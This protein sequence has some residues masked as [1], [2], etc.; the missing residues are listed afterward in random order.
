MKDL[1]G[2]NIILFAPKSF[3]YEFEIKKALQQKG[4]NVYLYDERPSNHSLVKALIRINKNILKLYSEQYFLK[5]LK[6]HTN[7]KIDYF[8]IVRGETF[9]KR[10]LDF[11]KDNF[12]SAEFILYLWD[13]LNNNNV[14]NILHLFDRTYSFDSHDSEKNRS[15]IFRP[16]FFIPDYGEIAN[17]KNYSIDI[18]F[19]GTVHSDRYRFIKSLETYFLAL[20]YKLLFFFFFQSRLLYFRKRFFDKSFNTTKMSD[21]HF[22]PLTKDETINLVAQSRIILD[23]QH[24]KQNGLTMRTVEAVGAK[25]K[26]ITTNKLIANYDFYDKNNIYVVDRNEKEIDI[27][28]IN[29]PYNDIPDEVYSKYKIESWIDELFLL[30]R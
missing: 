24:P 1:K 14:S 19:I 11:M 20:K 5:R 16:L 3:G 27:S 8:L 29:S 18:L 15:L 12:K 6:K 17:K 9:T 21:F 22:T 28:F 23:I 10:V 26:L 25:R 7:E 30:N 2:K 13:S 4:A